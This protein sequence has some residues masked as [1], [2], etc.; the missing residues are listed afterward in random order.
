MEKLP[1][2]FRLSGRVRTD[3][4]FALGKNL[5]VWPFKLFY[6]QTE[7][8]GPAPL[9]RALFSVPKRQFKHATD[10]NRIRRR[11]REVYRKCVREILLP[12]V[13]ASG[14]DL[15]IAFLYTGGQAKILPAELERKLSG[16]LR[17][18]AQEIGPAA[19]AET[20]AES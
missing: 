16:A 8:E 2:A 9:P 11:S 19:E 3:R 6:L 12:R 10:R 18:L 13:T 5:K 7:P 17:R 1:K 14:Q 15:H 4:L 20:P